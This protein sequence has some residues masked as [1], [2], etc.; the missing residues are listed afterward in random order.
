MLKNILNLEGAQKLTKNAQK[1]INGG[2]M[3]ELCPGEV[4]LVS[5]IFPKKCT[6]GGPNGWYCA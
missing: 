6:Q 4:V 2:R 5:C 3:P 1:S